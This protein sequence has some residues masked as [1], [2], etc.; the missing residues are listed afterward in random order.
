M[1]PNAALAEMRAARQRLE[2]RERQANTDSTYTGW[3]SEG[4]GRIVKHLD[5][6]ANFDAFD[7][8]NAQDWRTISDTAAALD[9]WLSDGNFLPDAWRQQ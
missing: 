4:G 2:E 5:L 3:V 7:E 9:A 8:A 6:D 1:D